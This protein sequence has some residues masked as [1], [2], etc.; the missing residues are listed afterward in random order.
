MRH[1]SYKFLTFRISRI[2][3]SFMIHRLHLY[4]YIDKDKIRNLHILTSHKF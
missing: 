4:I 2:Q 3:H 1:G